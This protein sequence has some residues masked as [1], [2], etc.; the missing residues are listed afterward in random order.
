MN[1]DQVINIQKPDRLLAAIVIFIFKLPIMCQAS[2][3]FICFFG[4]VASA[5]FFGWLKNVNC[6]WS[7]KVEEKFQT[8]EC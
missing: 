4:G 8:L 6:I 2:L 1:A 5:D 7:I 3:T